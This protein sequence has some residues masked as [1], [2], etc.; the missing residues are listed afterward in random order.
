MAH[1]SH[2]C[3]INRL[4]RAHGH[5]GAVLAMA[6]SNRFDLTPETRRIMIACGAGA[7][8]AAVYNVPLGG[9]LF[10]LEVLLGTFR[11]EALVPALATSVSSLDIW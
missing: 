5:L 1:L 10:T 11:L 4:K 8:L 3:I 6:L 7:G 2:P 9:A